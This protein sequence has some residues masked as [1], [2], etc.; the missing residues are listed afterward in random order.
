[1]SSEDG[2]SERAG[3]IASSHTETG[4]HEDIN[5]KHAFVRDDESLSTLKSP[6]VYQDSNHD[7]DLDHREDEELLPQESEKQPEPP[8]AS[9]TSGVIWIG[10]NTLATVGIVSVWTYIFCALLRALCSATRRYQRL[11]QHSR[12]SQ[13]RPSSPIHLSSSPS[14]PL[15]PFTFASHGSR[16]SFSRGLVSATLNHAGPLSAP[17]SRSLS[18]WLSMS[19][20]LTCPSPS[21]V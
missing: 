19:F 16:S 20:S 8:K 10:V 7:G 14:S 13:T 2:R 15:R 4:G 1:M 3:S 6:T 17:S 18:P 5:E 9:A 11:T 21:R 12:S